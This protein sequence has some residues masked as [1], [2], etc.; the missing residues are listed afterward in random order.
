M[1][2]NGAHRYAR[3][4]VPKINLPFIGIVD[5]TAKR[6]DASGMKKVGL[7]GVRH[8]MAGRFYHDRLAADGIE[9]LTP[10]ATDQDHP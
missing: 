8:T 9:V 10:S 3:L 4:I 6:I 5:A 2:A 1:C 7:Q